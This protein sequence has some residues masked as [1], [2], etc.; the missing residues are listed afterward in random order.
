MIERMTTITNSIE[1]TVSSPEPQ[2]RMTIKQVIVSGKLQAELHSG[3]PVAKG[4]G[5]VWWVP[6][7]LGSG[8]P[9]ED[10]LDSIAWLTALLDKETSAP[11]VR[12]EP[13]RMVN[14]VDWNTGKNMKSKGGHRV[15]KQPRNL[16]S[17]V[18]HEGP[19]DRV[20]FAMNHYTEAARAKITLA[21][22][23]FTGLVDLESGET[24]PVTDGSASSTSTANP[25]LCSAW[26]KNEYSSPL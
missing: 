20:L 22:K 13:E 23:L 4:K 10:S 25:P 19:E 9:E 1:K 15:Y 21:D 26:F 18:L 17:A 14:W 5:S 7:G 6:V 16:F 2:N 3:E 12:V 8:Q 11:K 24:I